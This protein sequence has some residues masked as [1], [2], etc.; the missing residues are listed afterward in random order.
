MGIDSALY[1]SIRFGTVHSVFLEMIR[2]AGI[3]WRI[4]NEG[5]RCRFIRTASRG[6]AVLKAQ[7]EVMEL[8]SLFT[9]VDN[10]LLP[11]NDIINGS[12]IKTGYIPTGNT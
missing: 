10:S 6:Y 3:N 9:L 8:S 11:I 2:H 7:E 4:I 5:E 1:N 12:T